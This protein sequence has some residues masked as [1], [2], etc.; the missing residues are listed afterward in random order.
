MIRTKPSPPAAIVHLGLG[1]FFRAFGIPWIAEAGGDWGVIGVS[2]RS[3]QTRNALAGQDWV[4]TAAEMGTDGIIPRVIENL[5]TVLVAPENPSAVLQ[6]MADPAIKIVSLTVTEKGYCHDPA[7]GALNPNHP[8]ILHDIA[9]KLPRSAPGYLVRALQMRRTNG[10]PAFTVMSCDNLPDN[11]KVTRAVTIALAHKIDPDLADWIAHNVAFP[12]TMIDRIVPATTP[13]DIVNLHAQTGQHDAAPVMHEPF[14]QWVIEDDFPQGRPALDTVGA[15]LVSDVAPFEAMKLRMLNGTHSAI[16]YLGYLAGHQY[17]SQAAADPVFTAFLKHLWNDHIIPSVP[18]P[19]GVDLHD[20]ASALM[21]RYQNPAIQ[22]ATWQI[23][24]DGSQKL[25]QRILGTLRDGL[26]SGRD[27]T[28]LLLVVAAWI[29]YVGGTDEAGNP[30]DVRDPFAADLAA[31][32]ASDDPVAAILSQGAV[33]DVDLAAQ[34]KV[35]LTDI[36]N[37]LVA[38]GARATIESITP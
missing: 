20:Y 19:D 11:G 37:T 16:A 36:Y 5:S 2:L 17:V 14:R 15:Q 21:A 34:V 35:P 1:A 3:P 10:D 25:P 7:A 31:C 33:F 24:M 22:H 27:V 26:D 13:D 32:H 8:D 23:A 30:I 38:K 4:Y 29:R 28:G 9:H 12:S 18:P 6:H